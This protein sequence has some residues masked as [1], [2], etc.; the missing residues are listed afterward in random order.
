MPCL[1]QTEWHSDQL[2]TLRTLLDCQQL[3]ILSEHGGGNSKVFCV[4]GD[5]KKWAVKS[6][7]PYAPNQRDRLAAEC[8]VYQF[9]NQ[10]HVAAIPFLKGYSTTERWLIIDWID[11]ELPKEIKDADITQAIQFLASVAILNHTP[12]ALALPLAAEACLSL[13]IILTQIKQRFQRL[14]TLPDKE[15]SLNDFLVQDFYPLFEK[16]E[17]HA[18]RGYHQYAISPTQELAL[19]KRSLIPA[20]FGFHNALRDT[21]GKL[22]F[23]DF[24]Y[25]GWDDPIKLLADV[26]WH[27]K[28]AL[29]IA[30]QQAFIDGIAKVYHEDSLFLTRFHYTWSLFGLRWVLILLNEFIPAFWQNRQHAAAYQEQAEAKRLQ[31]SRAKE[32]LMTVQQ[33]GCPYELSHTTS[34]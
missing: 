9:L 29:T 25:F 11:G 5:H 18:L 28:M 10:H 22:Y 13:E 16:C 19:E 2:A 15:A 12:D 21:Q 20:D 27:P 33:I 7:P 34:V 31:L 14:N 24:D 8:S 1:T 30:Q 6:Y 17:Q 26:L 32:L 23:F 4:E 3:T